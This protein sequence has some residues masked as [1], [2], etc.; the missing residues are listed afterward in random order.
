[1]KKTF[2]IAEAISAFIAVIAFY[3]G[4]LLSMWMSVNLPTIP[5][6][7]FV[8]PMIIHGKTIYLS[9]TYNAAHKLL[10]WGSMVLFGCAAC[11]DFYKDPFERRR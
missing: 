3:A 10:F 1:M 11:I 7:D 4:W 6:G 2:K 8:I 9:P 5:T